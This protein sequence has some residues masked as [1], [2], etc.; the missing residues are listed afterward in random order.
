ME[1][2]SIEKPN[3]RGFGFYKNEREGLLVFVLRCVRV[4]DVRCG[5]FGNAYVWANVLCFDY[6]PLL[7]SLNI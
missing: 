1:Y 4:F 5:F 3:R 2:S 7:Y 6:T